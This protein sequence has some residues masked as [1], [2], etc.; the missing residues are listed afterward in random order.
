M[1]VVQRAIIAESDIRESVEF[2]EK[3]NKDKKRSSSDQGNSQGS[4]K[5]FS[6][7]P[8]GSQV[9]V[10]SVGNSKKTSGSTAVSRPTSV[11]ERCG[12]SYPGQC[13]RDTGACFGCGQKGHLVK[14]CPKRQQQQPVQQSILAVSTSGST[15]PR[16][17]VEG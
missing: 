6:R 7:G 13:Y 4:K 14:D 11:C 12:K 16:G 9:S 17:G 2:R 8:F 1:E 5:P 3:K 10:S 15:Q